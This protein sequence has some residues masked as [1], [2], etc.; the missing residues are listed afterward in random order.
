MVGTINKFH[1]LKLLP[2]LLC[3]LM[4]TTNLASNSTRTPFPNEWTHGDDL[5]SLKI[6][7][8]SV[9]TNSSFADPSAMVR[10]LNIRRSK[11]CSRPESPRAELESTYESATQIYELAGDDAAP[12]L[13]V[14]LRERMTSNNGR[15]EELWHEHWQRN[16]LPEELLLLQAGTPQQLRT[17]VTESFDH[18]RAIR[19]SKVEEA[20]TVFHTKKMNHSSARRIR[21]GNKISSESVRSVRSTETASS[22]GRSSSSTTSQALESVT[23]VDSCTET[24]AKNLHE[25]ITVNTAQLLNP[26]RLSEPVSLNYDHAKSSRTQRIMKLLKSKD[27]GKGNASAMKRD[28]SL[29][30]TVIPDSPAKTRECASCLEDVVSADAIGLA[31]QHNYCSPCFARLVSTAMQHENFWP[32][33]CCLQEI[34]KKILARYLS[35]MELA[36]YKTKLREYAVPAGERWYCS[37]SSCGRW[38][39]KT[40]S[41]AGVSKVSC[42]HC[43]FEMCLFCRGELHVGGERCP[44][45]RGLEA[46]LAEAELDGWTMCYKCHTMIELE[47]GCRHIICKCRAEF[48]YATPI[49]LVFRN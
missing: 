7:T 13:Q 47:R 29:D 36:K 44:Q 30:P 3:C 21:A 31:C 11:G 35:D 48:W 20:R 46:T 34:P 14:D 33:K 42:T 22:S 10:P 6:G 8:S 37:S 24:P 39:E 16:E 28:L 23:T 45:D 2:K 38:F 9:D 19:E 15:D 43:L 49:A 40:R 26:F 1:N 4:Y 5:G 25:Q 18:F 41:R 17:I 12:S 32:P 27:K